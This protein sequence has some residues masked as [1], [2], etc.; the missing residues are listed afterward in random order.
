VRVLV[1]GATGFVGGHLTRH[2]LKEGYEVRC[3][4]RESS[5]IEPLKSLGVDLVYGDVRNMVSVEKAVAGAEKVFHIAALFR[6]AGFP[7]STYWDINV[8]GVANV[9]QASLQAGVK[10]F[11]H[12]STI[13][14][15]GHIS[16][17]PG[18][19][20]T[21]YNPGD[22]Y[23][24]TKMEGEKTAL[25][26]HKE[27]GLPVVVVRPA[28]IYGPGDL[29]LLK[30]FKAVAKRRFVMLGSGK[31]LAHFVYIDDLVKGFI[32]ASSIGKAVGNVY[33]FASEGPVT[34]N[35]L[36]RMISEK[37]GTPVPKLHL[38]V[39]PFQWMGSLCEAICIPLK[40]EPPIFRRRVDFFTKDRSF[41]I[42]KARNDLGYE[43]DIDMQEG[44]RR[45]IKWYK[46]NGYL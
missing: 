3:L 17:P 42:S 7:D 10:R 2:L 1:T 36:V 24:R 28:M 31:T 46:E 23:Q 12:C 9:L 37:L 22:I 20:S 18:N 33:I 43:Y 19:E 38:P 13:G 29:R 21:P 8:K 32:L 11:I 14:V 40:I 45:T 44:I 16:S 39:K 15:L 41:D 26:F 5:N 6:K 35:D 27:K 25:K 34:L 30:L 4:V